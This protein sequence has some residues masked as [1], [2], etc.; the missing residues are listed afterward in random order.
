MINWQ[1]EWITKIQSSP[2]TQISTQPRLKSIRNTS[3]V[4]RIAYSQNYDRKTLPCLR[5]WKIFAHFHNIFD[6]LLKHVYIRSL[7]C[8]SQLLPRSG[9]MRCDKTLERY[10][11]LTWISVLNSRW[12]IR[13]ANGKIFGVSIKDSEVSCIQLNVRTEI[14]SDNTFVPNIK[15]NKCRVKNQISLIIIIIIENFL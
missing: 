5:V 14:S 6:R 15:I 7:T 13:K 8:L 12:R 11:T 9:K 10:N 3:V 2:N 1:T 4:H